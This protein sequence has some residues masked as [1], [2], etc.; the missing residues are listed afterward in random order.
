MDME[1]WVPSLDEAVHI[2]HDANASKKGMNP[3]ILTLLK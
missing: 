1:T 2:S 3:T